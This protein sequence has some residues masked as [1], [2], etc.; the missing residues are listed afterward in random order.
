[1]GGGSETDLN[2]NVD[3]FFQH[4]KIK[5]LSYLIIQH[6]TSNFIVHFHQ[7]VFFK[8]NQV[9]C[10]LHIKIHWSSGSKK[11]IH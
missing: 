8:K 5:L 10:F 2:R 6:N 7:F 9:Y 1:M 3:S 4:K 11:I